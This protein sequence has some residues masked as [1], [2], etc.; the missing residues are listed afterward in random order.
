[1]DW[2]R[3]SPSDATNIHGTCFADCAVLSKPPLLQVTLVLALWFWGE[4]PPELTE[5]VG[6]GK[7]GRHEQLG[8]QPCS[9]RRWLLDLS[10]RPDLEQQSQLPSPFQ[11]CR[12]PI[13]LHK[14]GAQPLWSW[15]L[16]S[17]HLTPNK[18]FAVE[19]RSKNARHFG[20]RFET[21]NA[22]QVFSAAAWPATRCSVG[23]NLVHPLASACRRPGFRRS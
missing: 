21:K 9:I 8:C 4:I 1:M 20:S 15:S 14:P 10:L 3:H 16:L 13:R 17:M 11:R 18:F 22:K 2:E 5:K 6:V 12:V 7:E 19:S 23:R